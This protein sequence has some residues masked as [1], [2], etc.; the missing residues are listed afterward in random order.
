M[1]GVI[2]GPPADPSVGC[3]LSSHLKINK[4]DREWAL[5]VNHDRTRRMISLPT[6]ISLF[7]IGV[8]TAARLAA[9]ISR[10]DHF[11]KERAGP[12]FGVL[13]PIVEDFHD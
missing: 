3:H 12:V 10:I 13:K 9:E 4:I 8:E 11:P 5:G 6:H 7:L 1:S 2:R